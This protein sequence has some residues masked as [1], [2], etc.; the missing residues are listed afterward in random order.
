MRS[1]LP[2]LG[3]CL[4]LTWLLGACSH[5]PLGSLP[6]L[7]QI[8]FGATDVK[9]LRAAARVPATL[10]ITGAKMRVVMTVGESYRDEQIYALS[11]VSDRD[12]QASLAGDAPSSRV[13]VFRLS[14]EDAARLQAMREKGFRLGARTKQRGSMRIDLQ[15][16][17]C[18]T[19]DIGQEKLLLSTYLRSG[20]TGPAYVPLT[21]DVDLR[22]L[23]REG[24]VSSI[25]P[26]T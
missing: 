15:P 2:I 21:R 17:V 22:S 26:C 9:A 13:Q 8:D 24:E 18:R 20:E 7:A 6:R 12:K 19:A 5:V 25:P 23:G 16:N 11:E 10:Q 14:P 1:A 3:T 4:A